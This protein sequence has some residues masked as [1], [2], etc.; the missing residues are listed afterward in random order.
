MNPLNEFAPDHVF[1]LVNR[2]DTLSSAYPFVTR[3]V[4]LIG[5]TVDVG[6]L[7]LN[8]FVPSQRLFEL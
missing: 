7:V 5:V 6:K 2:P 8:A 4:A 1:E 3:S